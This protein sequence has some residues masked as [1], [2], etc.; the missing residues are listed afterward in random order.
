MMANLIG[1]L[2][3]VSA[4]K[5]AEL[6]PDHGKCSMSAC[7]NRL[8]FV[9]HHQAWKVQNGFKV[10]LKKTVSAEKQPREKC[11]IVCRKKKNLEEIEVIEIAC[12]DL[13]APKKAICR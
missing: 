13:L 5:L 11:P 2:A 8:A 7:R 1:F 12:S 4:G 3:V 6:H 9:Y 10:T